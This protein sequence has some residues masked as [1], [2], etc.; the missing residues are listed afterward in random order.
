MLVAAVAGC[1]HSQ[2]ANRWKG[3]RGLT[4]P[5]S[6]ALATYCK[7]IRALDALPTS[8]DTT[9]YPDVRTLLAAILKAEKLPFEIRTG[10]SEKGSSSHDMP[11]FVLGCAQ[12]PALFLAALGIVQ[13]DHM[14]VG[15]REYP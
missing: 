13:N 6:E 12:S 3:T 8:T 14:L 11:D 4:A 7:D 2:T 5:I 15:D 9:F 1:D 10:T